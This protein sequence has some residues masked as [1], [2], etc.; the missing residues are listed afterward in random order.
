MRKL[1]K[2]MISIFLSVVLV[3]GIFSLILPTANFAPNVKAEAVAKTYDYEEVLNGLGN[4]T[5]IND[6]RVW[7]VGSTDFGTNGLKALGIWNSMGLDVAWGALG[8]SHDFF[9]GT[10]VGAEREDIHPYIIY[11]VTPGTS[12]EL[13][14]AVHRDRNADDLVLNFYVSNDGVTWIPVSA[15]RNSAGVWKSKVE[16]W[17]SYNSYVY[18]IDNVG[19]KT[20][21][22]KAEYPL[23]I[24]S[25]DD[26]SEP[27]SDLVVYGVTFTPV[28]SYAV[29]GQTLFE[30]MAFARQK[31]LY[32]EHFI[33]Y[34]DFVNMDPSVSSGTSAATSNY[35]M[36]QN[37]TWGDFELKDRSYIA[38][39]A[40]GSRFYLETTNNWFM[41]T[42]GDALV[43]NGELDSADQA[44]IRVYSSAT[45]LDDE[46]TWTEWAPMPY[47]CGGTHTPTFNFYL[48]KDHIYVRIVY[49]QKGR[50]G[51]VEG[52]S[53][54]DV[55]GNDAAFFTDM[56]F[57]PYDAADAD[58][59]YD[60]TSAA[61]WDKPQAGTSNLSQDTG[62]GL[63]I[64][65]PW[66]NG[67]NLVNAAA[68]NT[69]DP[70]AKGHFSIQYA[71]EG[72]KMFNLEYAVR[73]ATWTGNTKGCYE[74]NVTDGSSME[75]IIESSTDN[76]TW[77]NAYETESG[78]A[79]TS[80]NDGDRK[81]FDVSYLVPKDAKFVRV[82]FGMTG[83]GYLADN[84]TYQGFNDCI[85]IRK[86]SVANANNVY[87]A[88]V[89]P[90][91][92][93]YTTD[94][95][96]SKATSTSG[97]DTSTSANSNNNTAFAGAW[98]HLGGNTQM[99]AGTKERPY[100]IYDVIP[101]STFNFDFSMRKKA[102][103]MSETSANL[104]LKGGIGRADLA[105]FEFF[106]YGRADENSSWTY[107]GKT[108]SD[109]LS[110]N[111]DAS[112]YD[113]FG[114][115][116]L[117][118]D[119]PANCSQ[120]K[121][122]LPQTGG[123]STGTL[124]TYDYTS[125]A[126]NDQNIGSW[127]YGTFG[128]VGASDVNK[129][130]VCKPGNLDG[131]SVNW[132]H[133]NV[134][135]GNAEFY[136]I[137]KVKPGSTFVANFKMPALTTRQN[138]ANQGTIFEYVIESCAT[139]DGTYGNAKTTAGQDTNPVVGYQVPADCQY[140][141]VTFPNKGLNPVSGNVENDTALFTG[142]SY[143]DGGDIMCG[144]DVAYLYNVKYASEVKGVVEYIYTTDTDT[145]KATSAS[146]TETASIDGA[147]GFR[148][149]YGHL[150]AGD[151]A[152][153]KTLAGTLERPYVIYDVVPGSN[154]SFD[155]SMYATAK[156]SSETTAALNIKAGLGSEA[157][158]EF[159]FFVYGRADENSAWQY[160]GKT[161]SSA[162]DYRGGNSASYGT[163]GYGKGS[164][165]IP[166]GVIQV[167][168][169]LPNTGALTTAT[170]VAYDYSTAS[171]NYGMWNN[172]AIGADYITFNDDQTDDS[173]DNIIGK[174]GNGIR[175]TFGSLSSAWGTK[176]FYIIY[177]V[178]PGTTF[179]ANFEMHDSATREGYAAKTGEPFEAKLQYSA[180][181][182]TWSEA[183]TTAGQGTSATL[184][185]IVPAGNE[186]VKITFPQ[187]GIIPD[188]GD[189]RGNDAATLTGV[190]FYPDAWITAG[191]DAA[192]LYNVKYA[193]GTKPGPDV[194]YT[195]LDSANITNASKAEL[196]IYNQANTQLEK[197]AGIK[198]KA[199][200]AFVI[201]KI[202]ENTML[203]VNSGDALSFEYS[204]DDT[205][206]KAFEAVKTCYGYVIPAI[207]GRNYIKVKLD[208]GE[209][210]T[211][212]YA[213]ALAPSVKFLIP[214][215]NKY[216][217]VD[218]AG[219]GD[220]ANSAVPTIDTL[221]PGYQFVGWDGYDDEGIYIDTTVEA[222]YTSDPNVTYTVSYTV[223]DS[224][225]T[226]NYKFDN[227]V[228]ISAPATNSEGQ[229]FSKWVDAKGV[230]VSNST[231]F[232]FLVSGNI[233]LRAVYAASKEDIA[234]YIYVTDEPIITTN[235]NGTWNLSV[236]WRTAMSGDV[237]VKETG[238][239]LGKDV[240]KANLILWDGATQA[241]TFK[242]KH[243]NTATNKT[244]I[245]TVRNIK[246]GE[247]RTA[248]PYAIL[249]NGDV[250]YGENVI[251]VT[252]GTQVESKYEF[253]GSI[254]PTVLNNYLD[255]AASYDAFGTADGQDRD[256]AIY[257]ARD[258]VRQTGVKY[259][260][261]G[262]AN[263]G[264]DENDIL[265][266]DNVT[267]YKN[268]IAE[269]H[270]VD[271][272]VIVEGAIFENVNANVESIVIP[273]WVQKEF[274]QTVQTGRYFDYDSM[275][276]TL[277]K[278]WSS[279][280]YGVNEW[281]TG[282][283]IPDIGSSEFQMYVYYK[284]C[285]YIDAG[286]EAIHFG[287]MYR[288]G[289]ESL[290]ISNDISEIDLVSW[291]TVL[292]KIRDYAKTHAR[293]GY[294]LVN[295]HNHTFAFVKENT[296]QMLVDFTASPL[297]LVTANS[298]DAYSE[299]FQNVGLTTSSGSDAAYI[300]NFTGYTTPSGY[301]VTGCYPYLLE[302]DNF[303]ADGSDDAVYGYD[304]ISWYANQKASDRHI[305]LT[306][307][308]NNV[309]G[310][311]AANGHVALPG[312]RSAFISAN[313]ASE[314][315]TYECNGTHIYNKY[316]SSSDGGASIPLWDAKVAGDIEAIRAAF[317]SLN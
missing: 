54:T 96:A 87:T 90:V 27:S 137:Y 99:L 15:E 301:P 264:L 184:G 141:K 240:D 134:A 24:A 270:E 70:Y 126:L 94:T 231:T 208:S 105:E 76:S 204:T 91:E 176:E 284:A 155:Y 20:N 275:L 308:V 92:Y 19:L 142:V 4:D 152:N 109:S 16:T 191:N 235:A 304:E 55:N 230:T 151:G 104:N 293:R 51:S 228:T 303:E 282:N 182:S 287:Q 269:I 236:V 277:T 63:G 111:G 154:F 271:P 61:Y 107:I 124:K 46:S 122:E 234:P 75:F 43:S 74:A 215:L 121:I 263:W 195:K 186:Y 73:I 118:V 44:R 296:T 29:N 53:Y 37:S 153:V 50:V 260:A 274:G 84:S 9:G 221:R 52:F 158:R 310:L 212:A 213:E 291:E 209:A 286:V 273:D 34:P 17:N 224:T 133:A 298:S 316:Y 290:S 59:I 100:V 279:S 241:N 102:I 283:S 144:N 160:I 245:Y 120:V 211:N 244:A 138:W 157:L 315:L 249:S 246:A 60:Y 268:W 317:D 166:A 71:V 187:K 56:V 261:R 179:V 57:T 8:I 285:Q 103:E 32:E 280:K 81:I 150:V 7:D 194:D 98:G 65:I 198:A 6:T 175:P 28:E 171:G 114:F 128:V 49:P 159:E 135:W 163:N 295:G 201:Y 39:V 255:R 45:L 233:A 145:S 223:G 125:S 41:K 192:H 306:T 265:S 110:L 181:K 206:Y 3:M 18:T 276:H 183:I 257:N 203:T 86:V 210:I 149:G 237:T 218:V 238:I 130:C 42:L 220:A 177:K 143:Y 26:G 242:M 13:S 256:S 216:E 10:A 288:I 225:T 189:Y 299:S 185:C 38:M 247:T 207:A 106:V 85:Y 196:N 253:S 266:G 79:E 254:S 300:T 248:L 188:S 178:K 313:G 139:I 36:L 165:D 69:E 47:S 14:S 214:Y 314:Y 131:L 200:G 116:S 174:D 227:R 307:I 123:F 262:I 222:V 132:G 80:V 1:S 101:G 205:T 136:L 226:N 229:V 78:Y 25:R 40:P 161:D 251:K 148:G 66:T 58:S 97:V 156:A 272:E 250:I 89:I 108:D 180:D 82:S 30:A 281:G 168:V 267:N 309:A 113:T 68:Q 21:F 297:R 33:A 146:N 12:F 23:S 72:G 22:V 119:I 147:T 202:K 252:N 311:S 93:V 312:K 77:T 35:G 64:T 31:E 115:G 140:V 5:G 193:S 294:V 127:A 239:L 199:D 190:S 302:F 129:F 169:E 167:K 219:Y 83:V 173:K 217:L 243:N 258:F 197:D 117:G 164:F 162:L 278:N 2:K 11:N 305:F 48:P 292:T 62:N 95:D 232:S 67:K 289:A 172:G 112:S 259:L 88:P 170:P